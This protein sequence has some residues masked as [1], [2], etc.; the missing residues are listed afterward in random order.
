MNT[1]QAELAICELK[2]TGVWAIKEHLTNLQDISELLNHFWHSKRS[3]VAM[4]KVAY[5][6]SNDMLDLMKEENQKYSI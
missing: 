6:V 1:E 3:S 4:L 2:N 5:L